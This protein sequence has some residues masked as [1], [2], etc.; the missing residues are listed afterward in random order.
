M[1]NDRRRFLATWGA[2][3]LM[4]LRAPLASGAPP[5]HKTDKAKGKDHPRDS[6]SSDVS[7]LIR[8]GISAA[9]ARDL[10][11]QTGGV[12]GSQKPLPPGIRKNL[13]RGKPIPP[14]I[15]KTR[16]SGDYVATLPRHPGYEWT[17]AGLDLLLVQT[18]SG[19]IADALIDVFQ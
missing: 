3:G 14:G 13:A 15:A 5:E 1:R 18:G 16:L 12:P 11:R 4:V 19:L 8:A 7:G 17:G 6:V 10:F 2:L 9:A